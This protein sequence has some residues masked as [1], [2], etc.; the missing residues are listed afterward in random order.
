MLFFLELV[1][2]VFFPFTG[3]DVDQARGLEERVMLED[4]QSWTNSKAINEI[5]DKSGIFLAVKAKFDVH[6]M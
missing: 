4:A 3:I 2:Q 1:S 5:K 6:V